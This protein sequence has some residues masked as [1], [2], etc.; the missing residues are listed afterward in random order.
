MHP[1]SLEEIETLAR[2]HGLAVI[3]RA[4]AMDSLGRP[5]VSWISVALRQLEARPLHCVW[6]GRALAQENLDID[7]L[8]PWSAWPCG[9]LWN[10]LPA[11]R[12]VNQRLKRDRLPAAS[13]LAQAE[14]G[15]RGWWQ[16]AYLAPEDPLL[17]GRCAQEARA[18][19]PEPSGMTAEA[20]PLETVFTAVGLQQPAAAP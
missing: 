19:L 3:R 17:P 1:V 13:T 20:S 9:D 18:S 10:L 11:H 8:F 12:L 7:H 2:D 6:T 5:E 15:I 4:D 14:E 16:E